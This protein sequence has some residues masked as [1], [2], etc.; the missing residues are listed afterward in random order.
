M[1]DGIK[2]KS[3][4]LRRFAQRSLEGRTAGAHT[5]SSAHLH[6]LLQ[7]AQ[8]GRDLLALGANAAAP[9]GEGDFADID[10]AARIDSEPV[11]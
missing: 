10:V 9:I 6:E 11:R 2:E 3:V 1:E 8:A 7:A 5:A 4:I